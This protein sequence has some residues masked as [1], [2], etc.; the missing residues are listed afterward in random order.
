MRS[1]SPRVDPHNVLET[2]VFSQSRINNLYSHSDERPALMTNIGLAATGS[3]LI[4]ISQIYIEDQ[5]LCHGTECG[6]LAQGLPVSRGCGVHW[7]YFETG[8]IDT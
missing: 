2:K 8:R 6:R 7:T 3:Y 5:L 1:S 4:I